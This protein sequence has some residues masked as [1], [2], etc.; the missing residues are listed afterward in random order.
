MGLT[1]ASRTTV[2]AAILLLGAALVVAPSA[3]ANPGATIRILFDLGDG[4][5]VWA[6]ETIPDPAAVNATWLA[7]QHAAASHHI[8]MSSRWYNGYGVF[9]SDLGGSIPATFQWDPLGNR[10]AGLRVSFSNFTASEGDA[11]ALY[12]AGFS[13]SPPYVAREPVPTPEHPQPSMTFRG[14]LYN[15]GVSPSPVPDRIRVAWDADTGIREIESTPAVAGGSLFASTM[16]GLLALNAST[17]A[18][19]WNNS[20]GKGLSSPAVFN[21]SVFVGTSRG[22]VIR[23]DAE[24]GEGIW[25]TRLLPSTTFTGI[26]SSPKIAGDRVFIGTFNESGG[27][28]EVVALAEGDG[29]VLW[30]HGTGSVHFSTPAV[31][32]GTVYVGIMGTY[33]TTSQVSFEPPY[34][35]VALDAATGGQKWFRTT[36]GSV[37]ASPAV[38]GP[39]VIVPAKDGVVYSLNRTT[40]EV[41]WTSAVDAGISSP[42]VSGDAV[43]VGCGAFGAPGKV[44]ALDT[45]TGAQRWS[46]PTNGPVQASLTYAGGKVLFATNTAHGTISALDATT[47]SLAW[48]YEPLPSEYILGSPVVAD[49]VVYA[50]SD[51]GHVVALAENLQGPASS[52][53]GTL[54]AVGGTVVAV[55]AV[56][57]LAW[58]MIRRRRRVGP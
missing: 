35:V 46:V 39:N 38:A 49:G 45:A 1:R 7:V 14:N 17:G 25:E 28:G 41:V 30:R 23:V 27:P 50:P 26:S 48:S 10:W 13:S 37:A 44:V 2:A 33:N 15:T 52:S 55:V 18:I 22:S 29:H 24:T 6:T 9:I 56:A 11:F 51:N 19:L 20:N 58:V 21:D 31:A 12:A 4:T 42:A 32:D 34:G 43:F 36:G 3:A 40:G 8:P 54:L 47:G 53:L 5:Y 57:V 16:R